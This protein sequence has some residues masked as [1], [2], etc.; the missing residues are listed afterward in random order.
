VDIAAYGTT[1]GQWTLSLG[2]TLRF[3]N[4]RLVLD[5]SLDYKDWPAHYFGMGNATHPDTFNTYEMT[6][7]R[8][9]TP[10]ETDLGL[11]EALNGRI[12]YGA[13]LDIEHNR[14][15][16]DSLDF[17][18]ILEPERQGGL[19]TGIGYNLSY[20]S[21]D[22]ENWAR[23]GVLAKWRQ[24]F[25]PGA[26]GNWNF[27]WKSLDLRAYFPMPVL[28]DGALALGGF[29]E[30][31]DGDAP[32][33]RLAQPDGVRYLRGLEKG[34]YR[35]RQALVMRSELRTALFWRFGGT[36]FYEA[37]KVGPYFSELMRAD[38]HHSLGLGARLAINKSKKLNARVDI[39]LLDG[40]EIGLTVYLREAF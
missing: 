8:L 31:V 2:P 1:R 21:T 11:P 14:T 13:E 35:D 25:F 24:L 34:Q 18:S 39:A 40:E 33:D 9:R 26:L 37:G 23:H 17:D 5:A 15:Q 10:F 32:F 27:G 20:N 36:I 3:F 38:W 7:W 12:R 19:R 6:Q 29:W 28:P 16:F 22:H 30:G 4:E